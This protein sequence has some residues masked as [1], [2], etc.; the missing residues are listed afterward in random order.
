MSTLTTRLGLTKPDPNPTTGDFV[1][2]AVLNTDF[3]KIDAA[4]SATVATSAT[5]PATPFDGQLVRETD[6]RR[7][8]VRN[9]TQSVWDPVSGT[10]SCT[11][12]TRPG[13]PYEGMLIR[14][15]DTRRVLVWNATNSAWDVVTDPGAW[16]AYTP[17]WTAATTNPTLGNGTIAGRSRTIGKTMELWIR[18]VWGSTTSSTGSGGWRFTIPAAVQPDQLMSVYVDDNSASARWPGQCRMLGAATGDN[19]RI[20]VSA[21]GGA[22]GGTAV[23]MTWA[24][25]DLIILQGTLELT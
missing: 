19:M 8:I 16:T 5:R 25:G 6:T 17:S 22:L 20:V 21:G 4:V 3:D 12:G 1:D 9:A 10:F 7:V 18:L 14:E 11:S 15:T 24:T 2:V 23:P 13:T